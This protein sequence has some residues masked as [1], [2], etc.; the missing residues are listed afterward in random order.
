MHSCPANVAACII[1]VLTL[2]LW[3]APVG[4]QG[5]Y[6]RQTV[7]NSDHCYLKK[8]NDFDHKSLEYRTAR[9][10][11]GHLIWRFGSK[12]GIWKYW[13]NLKF[14]GGPSQGRG[15]TTHTK[16]LAEFH[17]AVQASTVKLPNLILCQYFRLYG[18]THHTKTL[19][20]LRTKMVQYIVWDTP[21]PL[22]PSARFKKKTFI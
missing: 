8:K 11:G 10:I 12:R 15:T 16:I 7:Y 21:K 20:V 1:I 2:F 5:H 18:T 17:L 9:N 3:P 6:H 13:Q 4:A 22:Q 19:E 14:G